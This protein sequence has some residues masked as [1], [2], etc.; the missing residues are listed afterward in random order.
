MKIWKAKA[1]PAVGVQAG[2]PEVEKLQG[3]SQAEALQAAAGTVVAVEKDSFTVQTGEGQLKVLQLQIPG[4]KR[5]DTDAF[6]R[7]YTLKAGTL[8]MAEA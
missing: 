7:G 8:F 6:L 5:M 2:E 3:E 4:K 1:E